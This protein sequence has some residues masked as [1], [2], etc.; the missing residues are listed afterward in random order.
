MVTLFREANFPKE[1]TYLE[2]DGSQF[3]ITQMFLDADVYLDYVLQAHLISCRTNLAQVNQAHYFCTKIR[4]TG[5][6]K[7]DCHLDAG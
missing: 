1:M 4:R 5:N 2:E 6:G 3:V 7:C